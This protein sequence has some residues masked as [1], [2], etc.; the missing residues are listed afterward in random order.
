MVI[1]YQVTVWKRK[2]EKVADYRFQNLDVENP[3][4]GGLAKLQGEWLVG[5]ESQWMVHR[6]Y[7]SPDSFMHTEACQ[8]ELRRP[9]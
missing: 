4:W 5:R 8:E 3:C 1:A 7:K 2:L 6:F 9:V